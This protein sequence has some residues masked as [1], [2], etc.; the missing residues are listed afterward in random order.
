MITV[1]LDIISAAAKGDDSAKVG[2]C[3]LMLPLIRDY[4]RKAP[5]E[6]REDAIQSGYLAVLIAITK[7]D[8]ERSENFPFFAGQYITNE[9]TAL[10]NSCCWIGRIPRKVVA[11][12]NEERNGG[13]P[14]TLP[15]GMKCD[16]IEKL[17]NYVGFTNG[18]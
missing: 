12:Y 13:E 17:M 14:A 1:P 11:L 3:R 7:F 16:D 5:I 15:N 10:V 2:V 4:A 9:I 8:S 18:G 6:W